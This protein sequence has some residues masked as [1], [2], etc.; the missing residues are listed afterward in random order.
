MWD[1]QAILDAAAAGLLRE[2]KRRRKE[3][4][5]YGLDSLA[6]LEHHPYL[7]EAFHRARLGVHP[8][9]PY[10]GESAP[11]RRLRRDRERCDIV[12]TPGRKVRLADPVAVLIEQEAAA[13]TLFAEPAKRR[14]AAPETVGPEEACWLEV[15]VVGQFTFTHGVPLANRTY[16]SEL[17]QNAVADLAKLG[18]DPQIFHGALLLV[19][20]TL[21]EATAAH[22]LEVFT[23]RCLD[24]GAL[25]QLPLRVTFPITDRIG[26]GACTVGLVKARRA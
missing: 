18:R 23:H 6:E 11:R 20:Y 4:A 16:T 21:D 26:N 1:F 3:Q 8:E 19:L 13:A 25:A 15:K 22:D 14:P 24:K 5:V 17:L 2:E 7:H 12:L 10:P 9:Q